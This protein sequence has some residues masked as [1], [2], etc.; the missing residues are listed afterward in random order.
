M[1]QVR[2]S[3]STNFETYP[4]AVVEILGTLLTF[5]FELDEPAP[6]GGLKIYVDSDAPNIL[7][8]LNVEAL[9]DNPDFQTNL[10]V[11]RDSFRD[12][13]SS[14]FAIIINPGETQASLTLPAFDINEE[15]SEPVNQ[16]NLDGFTPTTF[17]VKSRLEVDR[18]RETDPLTGIQG[19]DLNFVERD[20]VP[21]GNYTVV[22]EAASS[23]VVFVDNEQQLPDLPVVSLNITPTVI[24]EA[25]GTALVMNFTVEGDFP[26][27]GITVNLEGDVARIMQQ[28]VVAQTRFDSETGNIFYRFDNSF[29]NPD[30]GFVVG[31][32]LDRF[33]LEDGD[34]AE[35]N[36]DPEAAGDGF[37]SNFTFTIT[38]REASI[39][40]PVLDDIVEEEDTEY[41]Y[42]LAEGDGYL[43]DPTANSGSFTVTDGVEPATSP[44]VGVTAAP[45]TLI[46]S[47]QTVIEL[48]FTTDGDIPAE[49]V[50]VQLQGPPRSIAEFDINATNPRLPENE[51]VVEGVE[52]IGGSI[53]GTD[54]IAGSLF[55]RITDPT[56][57][58]KVAVLQD[59][60][61][62]GTE[63]LPFTLVDGEK[64][65][66][67][68][69]ANF[70]EVTIN[71]ELILPEVT[72]GLL[73]G[74]FT[75]N[76]L[77]APYLVES[78]ESGIPILSV[79]L[80]S[81]G[82]IPEDGLIVDVNTDL[83][84]ITEFVNEAQFNPTAFGGQVISAI[85]NED[86][87]ATG[88]RVRMDGPN[89]VVN[90]QSGVGLEATGP[91]IVNFFIEEGEGY[92]ASTETAG[93]RVYDNLDQV[94]P[95]EEIP[96]I[97]ISIRGRS[98]G[99]QF[100]PL[101][102]GEGTITLDINVEG[103]IPPDG[104][105]AYLRTDQ[106][107]GLGEF[108][109][110]NAEVVGG[111]FPSPDGAGQG[112]YFKI[113]EPEASITIQIAEDD[114][115]EGLETIDLV[116][117]PL[118]EY[119]IAEGGETV[120]IQLGEETTSKILVSL[121]GEP[122][123]LVEEE[124]TIATLTFNL[125]SP[126]PEVVAAPSRDGLPPEPGILV[127]VE[128]ESL[129]EF[130][131]DSFAVTGGEIKNIDVEGGTIDI[132]I[133]EQIATLTAAVLDDGN[134]EGKENVVF[135][136]V[137]PAEDA[138]YQIST[139]K[140]EDNEA[141]FD[142][143]DTLNESPVRVE[144]AESDD[145]IA[146]AIPIAINSERNTGIATG[147]ID[148]DFRNNR[149]VDQTEDVDMYSVELEAGDRL[150]I[151]LDSIP[152]TNSDGI[153]LRG[154]GDLRLF[155]ADGNELVYND[156]GS[157]PGEVLESGRDAYIDF[158]VD[159]AG[160]YYIG[161]SQAF[162]ENYDPNVKGT[163]DGALLSP[164]FGLGAG[165]Y[166]L[167]V[168]INPEDSEIEAFVE[169]DGESPDS[170]VVTFIAVPGTFQGN[171]II[172]SEI[173]ESLVTGRGTAALLNFTF[174]VDGEIPEDGL[175]V[176][177]KS[178]TDFTSFLDD[179]T[180]TPRTAVGGEILG[181]IYDE[182][183]NVA[184]LRAL[185]TSPNASFPFPVGDRDTDDPE[186]PETIL[187][188]LANSPDY[189]GD[190]AAN[191]SSIT[192][193]DTLEQIP[194]R[195]D[196][197]EVGVTIEPTELIESEG[198]ELNITFT[199]TGD[200]APE[201]L[202]VYVDS[203]TRAALGEFDVFNAEVSGGAFPAPNGDAS[204]FY[205]RIFENTATI[206][207]A[208]FD[209]TTNPEIPAEDA[210][211]G[212]EDFTFS[213]IENEDYTLDEA[214]TTVTFTIA[215]NPDSVVIEPPEEGPGEP[216]E[217]PTDNDGRTT[218][219]D[220]IADAV[221]LG[222]DPATGNLS[223]TIDGEIAERFRVVGNTVDAT[224]DVDMYS[225]L[226]EEGE[227]IVIDIDA[228][229]IGSAGLD[230]ILDS[231]LRIFD[232]D[233]NELAIDNNS[234]APDEIFQAEGDPYLLFT[235]PETATYYAGI[236]AL[237]N[238]FY[239]P[240]VANSGSG[241][242]FGE[243]F[244]ADIYRVNFNLGLPIVNLDIDPDDVLEGGPNDTATITFTV[245]D[246]DIPTVELDQEGNYLSGGLSVF[247]NVEE[248]EVLEA[249]FEELVLDG[250]IIGEFSDET[251]PGILE[252]ILLEETATVSLTAIDDEIEE[253]PIDF[254]FTLVE[255]LDGLNYALNPAA[256]TG[257]F[258]LIDDDFL[259]PTVSINVDNTDLREGDLVTFDFLAQGGEKA[260]PSLHNPVTI[261]ISSNVTG[262]LGE[263]EL[264]DENGDPLFTTEG[265][266]TVS[267]EDDDSSLVVTLIDTNASITFS[268][269]DDG[270]GEGL[271]RFTYSLV[272][273]ESLDYVVNP[274]AD[275]VTITIDDDLVPFFGT[276]GADIF[277]AGLTPPGFEGTENIVFA[278]GG[279]DLIDTIGGTGGNI[280]NGEGGNDTFILL[281]NDTAFGG[282]GS[283]RF[284]LQGG[285]N[286]IT[287]GDDADQFW[288]ALG[289]IPESPNTITDF[290]SSEGDIL[291]IAG[292]GIR[293][294]DLT[295]IADNDDTLIF[296]GDDQLA[297]LIGVDPDSLTEDDFI[298]D[299]EVVVDP[300]TIG[301]SVDETDLLE[302][303]SVTFDFLAEGEDGLP[304]EDNIITI[305]LESDTV[306]AFGEFELFD[307][308]GD[309]LFTTEGIDNVLIEEND[310]RLVATLIDPNASISFSVLDDGPGEGLEQFTYTLVDEENLDYVVNPNADSVTLT[311]DDD[312]IVGT[313]GSDVFDAGL[314]PPGFDGT[315]DVVFARG[316][317]DL[318]DTTGGTGGNILNGEGGNDTFILVN[319]DTALG[320]EGDD[321]FF[322]QGGDNT[323]T[324]GE[325]ADQ[326]WLTLGEIP[327][328]PNT[329]TDFDDL[330]GDVL[331]VAGLGIGFNNLTLTDDGGDT[332]I[333][334]EDNELARLVGVD[335]SSLGES[336][337]VFI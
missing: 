24:S 314:T 17:T 302:G 1:T 90:F 38:E 147:A 63:V 225:F 115:E 198:T 315:N 67:D 117:Q 226:L 313:E 114:L 278:R 293:F 123:D 135:T 193:Y 328:S 80:Q 224:E 18:R 86:G 211:E 187:F 235:A 330:Q 199:V 205:F 189:V 56:A 295:L 145:T 173:V 317:D 100:P 35:N 288:L 308:D 254:D 143:Y 324:G 265:I 88:L 219:N 94:P 58:V 32:V 15:T 112:F 126:P 260:V 195:G 210:L 208:V 55:L 26:P 133:T 215:D 196:A 159:E 250:L 238:D 169:F 276:E 213:I 290:D 253:L 222:L 296:V 81:D 118:P 156:A 298:F 109:L 82:V 70:I 304:S 220:T 202:L 149:D 167:T 91:Q 297:R 192:F 267:I 204:G 334:L 300:P 227:T 96:E 176:I 237:G 284:F 21:V 327:E 165:E 152:F 285:D 309:A 16:V 217:G 212:I 28:F 320:G 92:I 138:D 121:E 162:N 148:F 3:T 153:V 124:A 107:A 307:E 64:Y 85:Y 335:S 299:P 103:E 10:T 2:F 258:T 197:P 203:E 9:D 7:N 275:R 144:S 168:D 259:Q 231:I 166:E 248:L 20:G 97:G 57:T 177:I 25:E 316:G 264:F 186:N 240:N 132:S 125:S 140:P 71:D 40:I 286:T 301:I 245:T 104:I 113:T 53:V 59:E 272:D 137:E 11:N 127:R 79:V 310:S 49:G 76:D 180:G 141:T 337:F 69:D 39:T 178:D 312:A 321:R 33:S 99:A 232:A 230:S 155:D 34:P 146:T 243:R 236:S 47:E 78:T 36:S 326:F 319:N 158:T 303:D 131:I 268:I 325:D 52:V 175:E 181:A 239:D 200:I 234:A 50:V 54:E 274:N 273:E 333:S 263:F 77:I 19:D 110:L 95:L 194:G 128:T 161:V 183:G 87:I 170:P 271:E 139:T 287:G 116:L 269:I 60:E 251:Q 185:L 294:E 209:E 318:L 182:D 171:D 244:G 48:T 291:G 61:E 207:L 119:T 201:G 228:N 157:A 221:D 130:D 261:L 218:N 331:G 106:V 214:A 111:L 108:D 105:I 249:Q 322:L 282:E 257:S 277:D 43:V 74:T 283:D 75:G 174:A 68:P 281:S 101:K 280:L 66:V 206:K 229:G 154:G 179:L 190:D 136:L 306:G 31:G 129:E 44:T 98:I 223:V 279:D 160:T 266:D 42:T 252:F 89:T 172:S 191:T 247:L 12:F 65:E 84:D 37:L 120:S 255:D 305:F 46:E 134:A 83:P 151:D 164:R 4:N 72:L 329:V 292:L 270:P 102:E 142:I 45:T 8:R 184:G 323:I 188:S 246:Q 6:I 51:T 311:I 22:P 332:L 163:G 30:N 13:S 233:G 14:G 5:N 256:N 29:V 150:T 122:L 73:G 27:G 216:S 23:S 289:E 41:T 336:N 262:A 93:I 242:T 62:E 241:W